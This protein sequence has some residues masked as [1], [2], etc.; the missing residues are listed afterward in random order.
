MCTFGVEEWTGISNDGRDVVNRADSLV[1][2]LFPCCSL[3]R[4][5]WSCWFSNS[6]LAIRDCCSSLIWASL[7]N[8]SILVSIRPKVD[9]ISCTS[10]FLSTVSCPSEI[11]ILDTCDTRPSYSEHGGVARRVVTSHNVCEGRSWAGGIVV[12]WSGDWARGEMR[13]MR[14]EREENFV[15]ELLLV[16]SCCCWQK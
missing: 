3:R 9:S 15:A 8:I 16:Y 1:V 5:S 6:R 11:D 7:L 2:S 10:D 14:E 12:Y 4:A 13:E